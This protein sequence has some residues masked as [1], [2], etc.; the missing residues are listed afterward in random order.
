VTQAGIHVDALAPLGPHT[1]VFYP[2]QTFT[3]AH[4]ADFRSI[5]FFLEGPPEVLNKIRPLAE[6]LSDNVRDLDSQG[7]LTLHLGAVFASNFAN[8]MWMLA[9]ETL[10]DLPGVDMKAYV[11]LIRE[12]VDKALAYGPHDAHTGP[13]RRGDQVTMEKHMAILQDQDPERA[14]LYAQLSRMIAERF[15]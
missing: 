6:Q 7:R 2:L 3:K 10:A 12:V 14:A 5:P 9:D 11:P 8:F 4:R 1:G 13:A 15:S